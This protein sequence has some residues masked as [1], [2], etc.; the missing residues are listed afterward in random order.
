MTK[1]EMLA[2]LAPLWKAAYDEYN[3]L[4]ARSIRLFEEAYD[5][6]ALKT[7]RQAAR[8]FSFREGIETAAAAL[9]VSL[10]ELI[11]PALT[12]GNDEDPVY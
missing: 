10:A 12:R 3:E 2:A 4:S 8:K 5:Q 7:A 1:E 6:A 11:D 9:G